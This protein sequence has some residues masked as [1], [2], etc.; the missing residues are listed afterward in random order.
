MLVLPER[1]EQTLLNNSYWR[2]RVPDSWGSCDSLKVPPA[3]LVAHCHGGTETGRETRPSARSASLFAASTAG[4][5]RTMSLSR[6]ERMQEA[7][8]EERL[9]K[10]RTR[11]KLDAVDDRKRAQRA[12]EEEL[13]H[14][15]FCFN[16]ARATPPRGL[17]GG[18]S[19]VWQGEWQAAAG[20]SSCGRTH[21]PRPPVCAAAA[22]SPDPGA[23][24][25]RAPRC[26]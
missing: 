20:G 14:L 10:L 21:S 11:A 15:V 19:S 2:T 9:A 13:E 7:A 3:I 8:E 26:S 23:A 12:R 4:T 25:P 5:V 24:A 1:R 6:L 22:A 18:C 16:G 17:E